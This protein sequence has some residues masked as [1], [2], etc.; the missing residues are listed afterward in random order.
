MKIKSFFS[1]FVALVVIILTIAPYQV[2]ANEQ[3]DVLGPAVLRMTDG[4][5]VRLWGVE[6]PP[7]IDSAQYLQARAALVDLVG[8]GQVSCEMQ[9]TGTAYC[10]NQNNIDLGLAM[11]QRGYL[12]V[13]REAVVGTTLQS[14]YIKAEN[15]AATA[16]VGIWVTLSPSDVP[17]KAPFG[18]NFVFTGLVGGYFLLFCAVVAGF[19]FLSQRLGRTEQ[20]LRETT[21]LF[22]RKKDIEQQECGIL[23]AMLEAELRANKTKTDAF[24]IIYGEHIEKMRNTSTLPNYRRSG[25]IIH[26]Y[27]ALQR[28]VFDRVKDRLILL[29]PKLVQ[30]LF[31]LYS[32]IHTEA[33][34]I[35]ISPTDS[36]SDILTALESALAYCR[37]L[38]ARITKVL[39]YLESIMHT[40]S[41]LKKEY[42]RD[43]AENIRDED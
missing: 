14:L 38:D 23:A 16:G 42:E 17:Q 11:V 22:V 36:S 12:I 27:P 41:S 43:D 26:K 25:D 33:E 15:F 34:Y 30:D 10:R 5:V 9:E 7:G 3:V 40:S 1:T 13:D 4:S 24:L 35:D 6:I 19:I 31:V 39:S 28:T 37:S 2:Y 8:D 20:M 21:T 32:F 18:T 29:N